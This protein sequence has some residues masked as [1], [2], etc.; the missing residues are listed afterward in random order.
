MDSGLIAICVFVFILFSLLALGIAA[1]PLTIAGIGLAC[2]Y[3]ESLKI[4]ERE[5][6][7]VHS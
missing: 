1:I 4:G 7:D 3:I 6:K 2:K 5:D